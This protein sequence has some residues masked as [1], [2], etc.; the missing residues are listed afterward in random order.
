MKSVNY[1]EKDYDTIFKEMIRSAY[2]K[3]LLSEDEFFLEHINNL[4]DIENN[5]VMLESVYAY[6]IN[7]IYKDMTKI[8]NS[9]DIDKATGN[10]LDIIGAKLGISRPTAQ[11]SRVELLFTRRNGTVGDVTIP[12]GTLVKNQSNKQYITIETSVLRSD[13]DT[14]IVQARS[15]ESGYESKVGKN[16]LTT[17][18]TGVS[19]LDVTNPKGS[20]GGRPA[21]TDKEYR[22]LLKAWAYSHIKGTKEAY[23]LYF[24]NKEG[25]D[26]YKLVPLW[27]GT[28]T[29]KCIIDP[30][31]TYLEEEI[32]KEL[33]QNV[34][35]FDDD[36]WVTGARDVIIDVDIDVNVNIDETIEYSLPEMEDIALRVE[37]AIY[38]YI[39][40]GYY[41]TKLGAKKY[42]QGMTIGQDFIP[43]KA[44]VFIDS[45][46]PELKTIT[47]K[48][49]NNSKQRKIQAKDFKNYDKV[50]YDET[51]QQII[52]DRG[53]SCYY[54]TLLN[55]DN[56]YEL[57]S[58]AKGFTITFLDE[59]NNIIMK[60]DENHF[61][62]N[63]ITS[64]ENVS[65]KLSAKQTGAT[66][67]YINIIP[68]AEVGNI[69]GSYVQVE[70]DE[71]CVA[72]NI[73]VNIE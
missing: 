32:A 25:V 60:S 64:F 70:D 3:Q 1:K 26:G 59:N 13:N 61:Y 8:Y 39:N 19:G 67:S 35:L 38:T 41:T 56:P 62:F 66:I 58:D 49:V 14:I 36:V 24:S 68:K 23:E 11:K 55:I 30:A 69:T 18:I 6:E 44:S 27:D 73:N 28:G 71:V 51:M 37:D 17:I 10:E 65:L 12:M 29:V 5:Y 34:Q 16:T 46:V 4:Q 43:H 47:F 50:A 72:G 15:V 7:N 33:L 21:Y 9:M 53:G 45:Q 52:G 40:G 54:N 20:G 57:E 42:Y 48:G 22:I 31:N 63:N 2:S